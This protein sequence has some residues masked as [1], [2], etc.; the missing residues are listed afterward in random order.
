M[1]FEISKIRLYQ[2]KS[3]LFMQ[4]KN[5]TLLNV[6]TKINWMI[7]SKYVS[8]TSRNTNGKFDRINHT[9]IFTCTISIIQDN[10]L[11]ELYIFTYC[12]LFLLY[13]RTLILIRIF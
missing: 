12:T 8:Y 13:L 6:C 10:A 3:I 2:S 9:L 1:K 11:V 7:K 5:T 4:K